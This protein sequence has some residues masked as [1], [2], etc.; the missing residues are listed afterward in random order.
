MLTQWIEAK[1]PLIAAR[2]Q[3]GDPAHT[4]RLGLA[5]PG[6]RR[7]GLAVAARALAE[8]GPPLPLRKALGAA[9]LNWREPLGELA[10]QLEAAGEEACVYGSL[11]WQYWS[12]SSGAAYLTASSDV[13][14]LFRPMSWGAVLKIV[15]VLER[16]ERQHHAF[17]PDGEIVLPDG[18]A[19]AWREI[20]NHPP[21][22]LVKG[23]NS[24]RLRDMDSI[25]SVFEDRV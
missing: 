20:S 4:L 19:I 2:S 9:P 18:D 16:F 11:A 21:K 8:H 10:D 6:K 13:D 23:M 12:A 7:I 15:S 5:L 25:R 22:V 14:L 3:P 24:A 17:R 1:R